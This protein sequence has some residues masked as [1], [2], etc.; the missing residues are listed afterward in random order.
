MAQLKVQPCSKFDCG[1]HLTCK[2]LTNCPLCSTFI[3]L[4][5]S[6][7]ILTVPN[8][9]TSLILDVIVESSCV[10]VDEE[11]VL[12]AVGKSKP[13]KEIGKI[14]SQGDDS[15]DSLRCWS[16][17]LSESLSCKFGFSQA[18]ILQLFFQVFLGYSKS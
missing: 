3:H 1:Q 11:N 9:V 15:L 16:F 14:R 12:C 8:I 7:L 17:G 5:P 13:A 6:H 18:K 4:L 2:H 10:S